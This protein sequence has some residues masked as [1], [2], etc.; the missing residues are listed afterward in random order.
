MARGLGVDPGTKS[1]DLV[2][3]D[4]DRVVWE[5]SIPTVDVAR[6][7]SILVEAVLEAGGYD[8]VAG[9]SGYGVPVTCNEDIVDPRRF[10]L[11]VL[12][13]TRE[14]DLRAGLEAGE[15]GIMVY[16]ALARV[17]EELWRRR[18]RVCYIPSVVL[19]PTV[20]AYRK[21]NRVD[22][23][24]ADKMAVA[25][26]AVYDYAREHGVPYERASFILVESGFGYNAVIG[27]EGG[28][29]VDGLGGTLVPMGFLTVGPIDAE[30]AVMAGSWARSD[31][32][33]GGVV[34]RCRAS[35]AGE[36]LRMALQGDRG[37]EE[38]I[39]AFLEG[40]ERAVA[41]VATT[42]RRPGEILLS[43]RNTRDE[44]LRGI[45]EERLSRYAPVRRIRGLA[46][47]RISKEAAQGYAI[48]AEGL[49][50]GYFRDLVEH[51]SI[52]QARGTVLDWFI[53]PRLSQ[54]RERLR[55][56][57]ASSVRNPRL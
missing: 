48:V 57:Y 7:P 13:L 20:P 15:P 34:D 2:L 50:G 56:A 37:C 44:R 42:V 16:E 12:L 38:A 4:G 41:S 23:G 5:K 6:S 51:M 24:T 26:L 33:H 1:F 55:E 17:V 46:G 3:V 28:R 49:A 14:E 18:L 43:G 25:A 32:F 53:H 8:L 45:L 35:D 52:P 31:V 9:P 40:I 27:V 39:E 54:A 21:L 36:A 47:A 29:I 22:M 19:L 10:A 30:A 11:E